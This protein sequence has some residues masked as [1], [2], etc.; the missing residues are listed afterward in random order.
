MPR[1][2]RNT[3][4]GYRL[5]STYLKLQQQED[6]DKEYDEKFNRRLKGFH[7]FC[8]ILFTSFL[9]DGFLPLRSFPSKITGVKII[10]R[11]QK[12]VTPVKGDLPP[13]EVI[14]PC[15]IEIFTTE[16]N[17]TTSDINGYEERGAKITV[18]KTFL[19]RARE[20]I[21]Y[22]ESGLYTYHYINFHGN[23]IIWPLISVTISLIFILTKRFYGSSTLS[24]IAMLNLV[25]FFT[26]LYMS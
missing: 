7:V 21:R 14:V 23:F 2:S 20:R 26:A 1:E 25:P 13:V 5:I 12:T 4:R 18:E 10:T 9:I 19:F 3:F 16:G 17:F 8:V 15:K 6:A 11:D 22:N 24:V